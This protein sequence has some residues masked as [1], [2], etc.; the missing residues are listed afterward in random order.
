MKKLL[1]V[2]LFSTAALYGQNPDGKFASL[3]L[4]PSWM[5]GSVNYSRTTSMWYPPTQS[6]PEQ[7]IQN[8]DAG[9]LNFPISFGI[10]SQIKIPATSFLTVSLMYSFSQR[11]EEFSKSDSETKYFS[12][13][14][15]QNGNIHSFGF[16]MSVYNLFSVYQGD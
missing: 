4:S 13:Y 1:F 8:N 14:C 10:N 6:S 3:H 7:S 16:T 2:L 9:A 5:W 11:F 12:Q 15:K